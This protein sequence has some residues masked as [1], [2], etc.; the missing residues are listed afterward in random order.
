MSA[1]LREQEVCER[2]RDGLS[3]DGN[4]HFMEKDSFS[5]SVSVC[6]CV[7][8]APKVT[9]C[10][11]VF[12]SPPKI[13]VCQL[14]KFSLS[15]DLDCTHTRKNKKS[16]MCP[17]WNGVL[18]CADPRLSPQRSTPAIVNEMVVSE[19]GGI[20][21]S[22]F[23]GLS[24]EKWRGG[25]QHKAGLCAIWDY[26]TADAC[27]RR[28]LTCPFPVPL[29]TV[30]DGPHEAEMQMPRDVGQL[31]AEDVLAGDARVSAGGLPA[32][33]A[34]PHRRAH[35]GPQPQHGT[36]GA[37][38]HPPPP[39]GQRAGLLREVARLLRAGAGVRLG[40]NAGADLQQDQPGAGPL[41]EPVL[42]PGPQHPAADA[43]RA[44]QLQV[45]LVLL[46]GLRGVSENRVGQ[47]LQI[48]EVPGEFLNC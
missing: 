5:Q 13:I 1:L 12:R 29:P 2:G 3:Q 11:T 35:Q 17:W 30:G 38:A 45:P 47:R 41:R 40:G 33:G 24:I 20:H 27:G 21:S 34:F 19:G 39:E 32:E 36:G 26:E 6:V 25:T 7:C 14:L 18:W 9:H 46:R 37:R 28:M 10:V 8:G 22:M 15:P 42:R 23:F 31:S 44:M 16:N 43:Q 48:G 4:S